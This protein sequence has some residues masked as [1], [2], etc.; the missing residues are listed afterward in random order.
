MQR[1]KKET[2]LGQCIDN[3]VNLDVPGRKA[4]QILYPLA[5]EKSEE[6]LCLAAAR[7]I[8]ESVRRGNVFFIAT[9]FPDRPAVT[10]LVEETDGPPGAAAI[11]RAV[12]LGL[13][14]VPIVIVEDWIVESMTCVLTAAGLRVLSPGE[15]IAAIDSIGLL[16]AAAVIGFPTDVEEAKQRAKELIDRYKPATVLTV[17]KAGMNKAGQLHG[18]R[19]NN[20]GEYHAKI[21]YL[22]LEANRRN[23]ATIGIGDGG[24]EIGM[25]VIE[26]GLKRSSIPFMAKCLCPCGQGT[27]PNTKTD[28]LVTAAVSNWGAYGIAA[29]LAILLKNNDILHDA[30]V[31]ERILQGTINGSFIDGITGLT[32]G[33]VDGLSIATNK[34]LVTLLGQVV[35]EAH[36]VIGNEE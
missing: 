22:I 25:G 29:C 10:P 26:E 4:T 12:L 19:G 16:R 36:R 28:V 8:K 5:R 15:A 13:G 17:E 14:G 30:A 32:N 24:N 1:E 2:V 21:D 9:G 11:A 35:S 23:I 3:L 18:R 20:I 34:A 31:E 6:P 27:A 33:S 7:L